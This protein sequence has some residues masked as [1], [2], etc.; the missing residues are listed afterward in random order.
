MQE[1]PRVTFMDRVRAV[2]WL[3]VAAR[4]IGVAA[5]LVAL[6]CAYVTIALIFDFDS[7][8]PGFVKTLGGY[9][10]VFFAVATLVAFG[11]GMWFMGDLP[12]RRR[13]RHDLSTH[14]EIRRHEIPS[15]VRL[16]ASSD[17][18]RATMSWDERC[19][20]AARLVPA[21]HNAFVDGDWDQRLQ[22]ESIVRTAWSHCLSDETPE[23]T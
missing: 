3:D 18:F 12:K 14:P 21:L 19:E 15:I 2:D 6:F 1:G 9:G 23:P 4:V 17:E 7:A 5:L 10:I 22:A 8:E 13:K 16:L 11:T 20:I